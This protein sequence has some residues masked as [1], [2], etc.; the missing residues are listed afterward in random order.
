V[1]AGLV[2]AVGVSNYS[3]K[4]LVAVHRALAARGVPLAS[5]QVRHSTLLLLRLLR[6]LL[7]LLRRC[8]C[9]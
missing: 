6:L 7:L 2:R 9:C 4:R 5:N 3:A 1:G 8:C